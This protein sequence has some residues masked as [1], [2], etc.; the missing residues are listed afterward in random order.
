MSDAPHKPPA[1]VRLA[2][3]RLPSIEAGRGIAATAVV[4]YH[5]MRHLNKIHPAPLL[6]HA[7]QFGHAGVDFFFVISGFIILHVHAADIGRPA[8]LGH[9][10]ARRFTRVFP[11][12]WVALVFTIILSLAGHEHALP[13]AADLARSILLLPSHTPPL[14]GIAW[15]LQYEIVFYLVFAVLILNRA[16]GI[17]L[18]LLWLAWIAI[19]TIVP[20][21]TGLPPSIYGIY[22]LEFFAG[23]A[24]ARIL[25]TRRLTRPLPILAVGL[26]GFAAAA[27][28]EDLGWLNGY[29]NPA[30]FAYGVPAAMIVLGAAAADRARLIALPSFLRTLG[31]AS[32]SIYLFQFIFIGIAWHLLATAGADRGAPAAV[33][34]S[35]LAACGVGGGILMSRRIEYP[36]MRRLRR[37]S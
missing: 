34:F 30:R 13:S 1:S 4:L 20:D 9:Y 5:A 28:A 33:I 26:A 22:N 2:G 29:A 16:A 10:A 21:P 23:M 35:I 6:T 8:R 25:A 7:F 27:L 19:G 12:Y 17:A 3:L 37:R 11:T 15:T 24:A 18:C 36:L 32:Y 14:L 31:A